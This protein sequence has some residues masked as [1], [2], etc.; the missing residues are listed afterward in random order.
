MDAYEA[1]SEIADREGLSLR[2]ISTRA[3]KSPSYI[4]SNASRGSS[5]QANNLAMLADTVG[6]RLVLVPRADVPRT[7]IVI[8]A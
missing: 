8:D 4:S 2:T 7:G 1:L 5:P 6:Y 3:G